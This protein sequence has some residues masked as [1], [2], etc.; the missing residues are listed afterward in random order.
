MITNQTLSSF[1][2]ATA[3]LAV[4]N[5]LI[6]SISGATACAEVKAWPDLAAF[7]SPGRAPMPLSHGGLLLDRD[8]RGSEEAEGK[9]EILQ[10]GVKMAPK[11][12]T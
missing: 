6:C 7:Y 2:A 1:G 8:R 5:S 10:Q 4:G 12:N 3:H 11:E 9:I